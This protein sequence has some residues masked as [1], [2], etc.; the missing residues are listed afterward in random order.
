MKFLVI[1]VVLF[2]LSQKS[3]S[4][5]QSNSQMLSKIETLNT[6]AFGSCNR[7]YKPQPLWPYIKAQNPQLWIWGGDNIYADTSNI[8]EII[9]RYSVQ[10]KNKAYRDLTKDIPIL[11]VWDDHDYGHDN[12]TYTN[13][14]KHLSQ[15][16]FLDFLRVEGKSARRL[17]DGIYSSHT[18]GKN[19]REVKFIMLDNR[20]FHSAPGANL[21][22][23]KQWSWLE[24]ELKNSTAKVHFIM[25]GISITSPSLIKSEEWADHPKALEKLLGLVKEYKTKGLVF[26]S[27]D[28]HFSS[29]FQ[30]HGHL[31]F[32]SSGLTHTV[33]SKT[34]RVYVAKKYPLS[35][36]GLSYG[37]V[38]IDWNKNPLQLT[39]EIRTYKEEPV[40]VRKY[41]L[42]KNSWTRL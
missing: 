5:P 38:D 18:F 11:G 26:L 13:N 41:Q 39:L 1:F 12:A 19:D 33:P 14:I 3:F 4:S 7:Q 40:F 31:E 30:R 29:I 34:A 36:F 20:F 28:K 42:I 15:Q 17:R 37:K 25:S 21:L 6:F 27:G 2:S 9:R 16:L 32:M 10:E 35:F 22:G 23:Q 24:S 8:A